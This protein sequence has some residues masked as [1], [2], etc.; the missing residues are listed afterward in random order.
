M[1]A[2]HYMTPTATNIVQFSAPERSALIEEFT[3]PWRSVDAEDVCDL[4]AAA[5][6]LTAHDLAGGLDVP[7]AEVVQIVRSL[8]SAGELREDEFG[9]YRLAGDS[10]RRAS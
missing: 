3:L 2:T 1:N 6:S 9:R 10:L 7:V 8:A 5:G 4:L